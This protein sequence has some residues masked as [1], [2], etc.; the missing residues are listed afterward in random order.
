MGDKLL[1]LERST[2]R[3]SMSEKN[4]DGAIASNYLFIIF[5]PEKM[6]LH[7]DM[8]SKPFFSLWNT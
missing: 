8:E 6:C 2:W 1:S 7:A 5:T 4:F 3:D